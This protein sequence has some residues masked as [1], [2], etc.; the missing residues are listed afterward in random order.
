MFLELDR[1]SYHP[2]LG[3]NNQIVTYLPIWASSQFM[4]Q[5]YITTKMENISESALAEA[6]EEAADVGQREA[7]KL[8]RMYFRFSDSTG[9]ETLKEVLENLE[10]DAEL[11]VLKNSEEK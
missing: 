7:V 1:R 8:A 2:V 10:V 3:W 11:E 9:D 6:I 4:D 5:Q